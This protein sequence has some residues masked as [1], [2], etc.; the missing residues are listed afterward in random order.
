MPRSHLFTSPFGRRRTPTTPPTT[1]GPDDSCPGCRRSYD[2]SKRRPV[3][4]TCGH[5]RCRACTRDRKR[6]CQRCAVGV[7]RQA[8]CRPTDLPGTVSHLYTV[9]RLVGLLMTLSIFPSAITI[10]LFVHGLFG[11]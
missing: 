10:C 6:V 8:E 2:A 5:V 3:T 4:D 7:D 9:S 1:T 11:A